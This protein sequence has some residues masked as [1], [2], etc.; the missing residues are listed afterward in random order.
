MRRMVLSFFVFCFV[1]LDFHNMFDP[2]YN[3]LIRVYTI[4]RRKRRTRLFEFL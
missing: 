1:F 2:I 3:S 4:F